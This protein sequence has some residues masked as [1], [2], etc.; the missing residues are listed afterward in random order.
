MFKCDDCGKTTQPGEACNVVVTETRHKAYY[1]KYNN[2]IG[3]GYETVKEMKLCLACSEKEKYNG[4][5][6]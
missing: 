6:G 4:K 1:D 5:A 3:D 2:F